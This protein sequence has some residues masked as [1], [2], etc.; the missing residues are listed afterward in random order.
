MA[1]E[2]K[3]IQ[4]LSQ[5][6][7]MTPQLQQAI[8]LLQMDR[9]EFIEAIQKEINENPVLEE[10]KEQDDTASPEDG[11][12][13]DRAEQSPNKAQVTDKAEHTADWEAY[14]ERF[15][16]YQGSA[17][18]KGHTV[19][20]DRPPIEATAS[21]E[22]SLSEHILAQLRLVELQQKDEA[23]VL[24]V[25]GNLD[26][27]GYLCTTYEEIAEQCGCPLDDV[28][29]VLEVIK[30]LDPP[31]VGARNLSEC[32]LIQ[33]ENIGMG[34]GLAA[35]IVQNHLDK[36]EKRKYEAIA[37]QEQVAI[38]EVYRAISSIQALE[39]RPGR[40]FSDETIRYIIPDIYVYKIGG[41]YVISLN[42]DGMPKLRVSPYYLDLLKS[43][44]QEGS[45]NRQYLSERMKAASWLIRSIHQRQQ[46]IYKVTESIIKFQRDFLDYGVQKLRPLVLK[47]VAD[48]IG[49][50]ESTV[51][52]VTANKYMHTPQGVFELK[53]FFSSG[54]RTAEGDVSSSYI[55]EKIRSIIVEEPPEDPISDQKIVELLAAEN[56]T[57]ARRTVAKYRETLG[58]LS[59]SKRK[60]LF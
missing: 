44:D 59:S 13:L 42:D 25:V 18:P 7:L 49:M 3:L 39:P 32:L 52:R 29:R 38:D 9:M 34:D 21:R 4:K 47:E 58:I 19:N 23:I 43:P 53:Y 5:N 31:G 37:K 22:E 46:T 51:S 17:L 27:D 10:Q 50:H 57:I 12:G 40:Q 20:N 14:L 56:I 60:K 30:S 41:E 35:R 55:K 28:E 16:D 26:K 54:I 2:V 11:N 15:N 45:A 8:K 36:V 1:L 48:D 24:Q 33:L 6:L